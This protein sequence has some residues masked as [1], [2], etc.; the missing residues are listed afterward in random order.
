[1]DFFRKYGVQTDFYFPLIKVAVQNFAVS[2]DYTHVSGDV[3]VSKDGGAAATATNAPSAITMGNGAI[4]KLTL[5]ATEMSAA[6][7]VVTIIDATTKAIE[8]QAILISTYGNASAQHPF[9]LA[10][11]TQN[12]N[13]S[14][15][16][17]DAITAA[18][19]ATDAIGSG[20]LA[21]SAIA[22]I[23]DGVW[24]E[25]ASGHLTAGSFGQIFPLRGSTAQAGAAGTITLDA[26]A[27]A[28][29]SLYNG[30]IVAIT[31]GTG[32]GQAR[33]ITAYVGATKVASVTPNWTTNPDSSSVFSILPF[34]Y[35]AGLVS[36]LS[37]AITNASFA[38]G[39]I[40]AAA[41]AAD[42]IGASELAAD[43]VTEIQSGLATA[44]A[45]A[46]VQSDTDD[47]QSR[48]PAALV[49]GRIDASVG[50]MASA[51]VTATAI[52]TDAI[53]AAELAADGVAE[54]AGAVWDIVA[55]S[56]VTAGTFGQA[57]QPMRANTAQAGASGSITL[58]A[59]AS[60]VDDFY[61]GNIVAISS[62]TGA[63]QAR[64]ITGYTGSTKV[65]TVSPNW[66]T[67]PS[68]SSIFTV[69]PFAYVAGLVAALSGAITSSSFAAGAIDASAIA[70]D[71][72]GS[73]ELAASA[74]TE[75]Q[76][77]L[78]TSS[79]LTTVDSNV[80][81][82]KNKTDN[83]PSDPADASDIAASFSTVNATLSTIAGYIDTEVAAIL[84]AVDT[85]VAAIKAKT[86]NL[87]TDPADASDIAAAFAALN[88]IS[89]ANI[90]AGVIEGSVTLK[91]T[92]RLILA[93]QVGKSSGG[94]TT[95]VK[96]RD[97]ADSKD[98]I[99]AT[100]NSSGNRTAV[101]L[102]AT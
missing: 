35:T 80:T 91:D 22:E 59:S 83:L 18:A 25:I 19:I 43:A 98:R 33:L 72:I 14:T 53:G 36:V 66:A 97:T 74:V 67:N 93:A 73:A 86:D 51:V 62:G 84:A 60:A 29:N 24:D 70:T 92:L 27:S 46:G 1:M 6:L 68:S 16:S 96:F 31:S 54:I 102:D 32:V 85:E 28:T 3:K 30:C 10:T 57:L 20:E 100:V 37:G 42:A 39:A 77:G 79:A 63:G 17:N 71:A 40:D 11:A 52:A 88:N 101:T 58:D 76:S 34:A 44:S 78:A 15:I 89:V 4:W 55:S 8:D 99:S 82:I 23:A 87:P 38:A 9:D 48:L 75:I 21:A 81:A 47:I 95:T 64:L 13:V 65:A 2:A 45:V 26:S 50:A 56:H 49:S 69:L 90:L 12:V 7:I 94:G 5:T 41:I 61:K